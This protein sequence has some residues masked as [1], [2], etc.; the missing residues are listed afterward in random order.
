[1]RIVAEAPDI[2]DVQSLFEN[3][4]TSTSTQFLGILDRDTR[5]VEDEKKFQ[6]ALDIADRGIM[7]RV[8]L[9]NLYWLYN[10]KAFRQACR[11][12]RSVAEASVKRA[13]LAHQDDTS[14]KP[15]KDR[16]VMDDLILYTRDEDR[17]ISMALDLIVAGKSTS[18]A[19]LS[20]LVLY[21]AR[22]TDSYARLRQEVLQAFGPVETNEYLTFEQLKDCQYLQWCMSETLRLSPPAAFGLA[23][24]STDVVLPR[25]GGP[26]GEA[27]ILVEKVFIYYHMN[28]VQFRY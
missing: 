21:L 7:I 26:D 23:T 9:S 11:F 10:S 3:Y 17:L 27:P 1:M 12:A 19:L 6:D 14:G 25:G 20:N 24:A 28:F 18:S 22:H 8:V 5:L 4:T 2:I 16:K 15:R 13:L